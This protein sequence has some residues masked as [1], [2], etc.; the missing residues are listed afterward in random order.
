MSQDAVEV[1]RRFN[2]PHEG[3]DLMPTI[4]EAVARFGPEPDPAAVLA[5]WADDPSW[6]HVDEEVEWDTSSIGGVGT[7]VKGPLEVARWWGDWTEAWQRY[8]YTTV[9]YR[10]LGEVVFSRVAIDARGPGDVPVEMTVFQL[11]EVCAGKVGAGRVFMSEAE[12]LEAAG[13]RP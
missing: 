7:K 2:D 6:R 8:T 4:R 12:A 1:V 10:D 13:L 9:E 5:W 11:W 3:Q